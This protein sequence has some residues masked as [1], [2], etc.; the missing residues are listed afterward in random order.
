MIRGIEIHNPNNMTVLLAERIIRGIEIH[1]LNNMK[2][3][4][5]ERE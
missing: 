3:L 5:A 4:L 2:A 1:N